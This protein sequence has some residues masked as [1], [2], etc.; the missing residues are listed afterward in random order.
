MLVKVEGVARSNSESAFGRPLCKRSSI[1]RS[2]EAVTSSSS[3]SSTSSLAVS[4]MFFY[5]ACFLE[6]FSFI[7]IWVNVGYI[8]LFIGGR[9]SNMWW[10]IINDIPTFH[11]CNRLAGV[12]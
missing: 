1:D 11:V 4:E 5:H 12:G 3:G 2:S 6:E 10:H 7:C 8:I 9:W